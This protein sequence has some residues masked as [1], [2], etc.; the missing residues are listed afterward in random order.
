MGNYMTYFTVISHETRKDFIYTI[1]Y[2]ENR[3][4]WIRYPIMNETSEEIVIYRNSN[5]ISYWKPSLERF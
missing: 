2:L 1:N 5:F 4:C 3:K